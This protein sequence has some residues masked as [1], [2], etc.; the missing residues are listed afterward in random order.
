MTSVVPT[1]QPRVGYARDLRENLEAQLCE[2]YAELLESI[3]SA[4]SIDE[5]RLTSL[6]PSVSR[7]RPLS[8]IFYATHWRIGEAVDSGTRDHILPALHELNAGGYDTFDL[9]VRT[10]RGDYIDGAADEYLA[11]REGRRIS[12]PTAVSGDPS[13]DLAGLSTERLAELS[14][15]VHSTIQLIGKLDGGMGDEVRQYVREIRIVDSHVI[16][17]MSSV[18]FFGTV[19]LRQSV[20]GISADSAQVHFFSGIVHETSHHHLHALMAV[21]PLVLNRS[22]RF[23][24]P[25]RKDKRP[26]LGI[27]HATFV[28]ARL[29]HMFARWNNAHP[30]NDEVMGQLVEA[31]QRLAKGLAT[32]RQHGELTPLG[33]DFLESM[34]AETSIG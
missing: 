32:V 17:G 29:S 30:G 24:S 33:A 3:E 27:Y 34:V 21:D 1:F 23:D 4:L 14:P 31:R 26:M 19:F 5:G 28:L 9:R 6:A 15:L 16:G 12:R 25:L 11:G 7:D 18:R 13:A 10:Y 22:E 2:S 20:P 8:S